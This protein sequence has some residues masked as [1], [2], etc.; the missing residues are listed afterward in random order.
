MCSSPFSLRPRTVGMVV[1]GVVHWLAIWGK[2]AIYD[3]RLGDRN[4][5][6]VKLPAGVLS[7]EH[8]GI[9]SWGNRQM[10]YCSMVRAI[11]FGFGDM[12]S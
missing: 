1:A 6:L 8:E 3:P 5:A 2:L 4:V 11:K 12:G 9:C 7:Q 10:G